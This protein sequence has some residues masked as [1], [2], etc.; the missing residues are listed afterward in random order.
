MNIFKKKKV[1]KCQKAIHS[2]QFNIQW[3]PTTCELHE[4]K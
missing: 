2:I 3:A 4:D 1:S